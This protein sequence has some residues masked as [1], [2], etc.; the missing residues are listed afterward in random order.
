MK[1]LMLIA[2]AL[3]VAVNVFAQGKAD[4]FNGDKEITWLG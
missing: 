3:L 1:K 2:I 4:I